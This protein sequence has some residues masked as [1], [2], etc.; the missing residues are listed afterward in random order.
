MEHE[1]FEDDE[2]A[3]F[4]NENFVCIKVDREERPDL[5]QI[6][7]Q[8][9]QLLTGRGG[10]PMSVFLTPELEPF[11]GGTYWP[12]HARMNMPGFDR[13]LHAV[14]DAWRNRREQAVAQAR[15]L[16]QHIA[17]GTTPGGDRELTAEILPQA[18]AGLRQQFDR[19]HGGFGMA[20]EVSP[21]DESPIAPARLVPPAVTRLGRHGSSELTQDGERRHL[22]PP[23]GWVRA[24]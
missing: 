4:L 7:M 1:S 10:W 11:F 19:A 9:V 23:G 15:Q 16:A 12:P 17:D 6:Y 2:I 24:I 20:P 18:A 14:M 5:D 21:A 8:A 22:R 3:G 13:V